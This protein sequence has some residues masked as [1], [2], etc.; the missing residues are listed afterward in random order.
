VLAAKST[1]F[2]KGLNGPICDWEVSTRLNRQDFGVSADRDSIQDFIDVVIHV[3]ADL[4]QAAVS[5]P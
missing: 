5:K 1:G 2:G 3:E 4:R